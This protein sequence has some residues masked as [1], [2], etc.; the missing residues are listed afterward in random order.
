M[1][2]AKT[3]ANLRARRQTLNAWA[4]TVGRTRIR[5]LER[6][7]DRM[8]RNPDAEAIHEV[9]VATRRLRAAL[10]HLARCFRRN[11][12]KLLRR[13]S[14]RLANTM[15]EMRDLDILMQNLAEEKP[16]P[17]APV[18]ELIKALKARRDERMHRARPEARIL[19]QR[20]P[21]WEEKLRH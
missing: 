21:E 2:V 11:Q 6:E 13:S 5:R 10:R 3:R 7:L 18:A 17:G 9:R 8:D 20:L 14:S 19:R 15:G 16:Q 4:H 12:A 1:P